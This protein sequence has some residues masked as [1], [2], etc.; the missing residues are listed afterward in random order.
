MGVDGGGRL[1]RGHTAA[2]AVGGE[3]GQRVVVEHGVVGARVPVLQTGGR[4]AGQAVHAAVMRPRIME[5]NGGLWRL[6]VLPVGVSHGAGLWY[7]GIHG[8]EARV[9]RQPGDGARCGGWARGAWRP[10]HGP[11]VCPVARLHAGAPGSLLVP[12]LLLPPPLGA[13]VGEPNLQRLRLL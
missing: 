10:Q 7:G 5:D 8:V 2:P 11:G 6:T 4:H 9:E 3:R 13:P 12:Q 1:G